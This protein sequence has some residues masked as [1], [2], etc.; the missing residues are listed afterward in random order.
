MKKGTLLFIDDEAGILSALK[1]VLRKSGYDLLTASSAEEA[2]EILKQRPADLIMSDQRMPGMTGVEFFKQVKS[3]YPDTIRI[4]L[5]GYSEVSTIASAVNEG[6]IYRFITK[7]WNDEELKLAIA[8][9]F[10]QHEL[11]NQN[12]LLLEKIKEKNE[13]LEL[14]NTGL[15][16]LV[17][18][19]TRELAMSQKIL[20]NLP[21]PV[22]GVDAER[23]IAYTNRAARELLGREARPILGAPL[24]QLFTQEVEN[25]VEEACRHKKTSYLNGYRWDGREFQITCRIV[26]PDDMLRGVT[27]LIEENTGDCG[28]TSGT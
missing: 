4:V 15:E 11:R 17:G 2:L 18:E 19:R 5:S 8:Q 16:R 21:L 7:P 25:L 27:L 3:L 24:A 13:E 20:E 14:L 10:E 28:K 6:E 22:V 1:R 9:S 12:R 23:M 26:D